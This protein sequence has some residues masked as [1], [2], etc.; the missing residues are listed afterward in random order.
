MKKRKLLSIMFLSASILS[1]A[2][3]ASCS[4]GGDSNSPVSESQKVAD[5][6]ITFKVQDENGEWKNYGEPQTI[7][8][9]K[10]T[11]PSNPTKQYYTFRGWFLDTN[12]VNEFKNENLTDGATVYAYFVADEVNIVING[13]SEGTRDLIDVING[14]Y[15][16]GE[17]LTFDGWYTDPDCKVKFNPG[18]PAKTLYAQSVA[19]ITFNNGYEDVYVTK[20][21]PN[22]TVK[23]PAL[24]SVEVDGV[25][26]TVEASQI[27][28]SYMSS[29]DVYYLDDDGNEIDFTKAITKN[30]NVHVA[31]K[32][33]FLK[34]KYCDNGSGNQ[35]LLCLGTYGDL[36]GSDSNKA[37]L[38]DVPVISFPSKVTLL[39]KE[40]NKTTHDIKG[41]YVYDNKIFDSTALKKVIVQEGIEMIR[42]FS[43]TSGT[44]GVTSFQLP[45]T[46]RI[47]Q[48]SFNNL[49]IDA[50]SV[51]IPSSVEAIYDCFFK[52]AT[53]NYN[54]E[55][56]TYYTGTA[57]DF[58]I[59][60]PDSVKS[61]SIV[62]L[63]LKFSSNSTFQN[64]GKMITQTTEK[65][66]VLI[67][68]NE[69]DENGV[70]KVPEG[71]EGIQVG[72]FVN[73]TDIR[74]LVL[75]S[76]LK[77][78]NYNLN[79]TDFQDCYGWYTGQ[80]TC[81]ECYL[82]NTTLTENDYAY[83]GRLVVSNLETINYLVFTCDVDD[84]VYKAFAG[85]ASA[86]AYYYGSFTPSNDEVYMDINTVNLKETS[87]PKVK[88][89]VTNSFTNDKYTLTIDRENQNAITYDEIFTALDKQYSTSYQSLISEKKV[90]VTKTLNMLENYDITSTIKTNL[91]M[92]IV[93]DY[94]VDQA[95][96][97]YT[98]NGDEVTITGFDEKTAINL[99][100]DSYAVIIPDVI[101]GKNVTKIA[102]GAFKEKANIKIVKL[103]KSIKTIEKNAFLDA[104][105]LDKIDFN[106]AKLE[107]IGESAFENTAVTSLSFSIASLKSVETSAFKI[108][109][110]TKFVPVNGEEARDVTNVNDG[111]FYFVPYQVPNET[112]T[113]LIANYLVLN[114][115]VSSVRDDETKLTT[116]DA[117]MYAFSNAGSI[118]ECINLG[119]DHT[120]ENYIVRY[121]VMTGAMTGLKFS[122]SC[123]LAL[124][125]V[126][127]IHTNAITDTTVSRKGIQYSAEGLGLTTSVT[128]IQTLVEALPTVFEDGWIDN[129]DSIKNVKVGALN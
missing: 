84:D 1:T 19:T 93:V 53:V 74:K 42:G 107:T 82:Y 55:S 87:T 56:L 65:G 116:Y 4:K 123:Y 110:L 51:V 59:A 16:P 118:S 63:N 2:A 99:G 128:T 88:I 24:D 34:Y 100:D 92:D 13:E 38:A 31:W 122:S 17:G 39:D 119:E 78:I 98:T 96:I 29:E 41:V 64:D 71:I 47:M 106:G 44:S 61:L 89:T 114:Q 35:I 117:K 22:E 120:D 109:S 86:Y 127:K 95:G 30:M 85:N 8:N 94:I 36:S 50:N 81:N 12:W 57:Y 103:G 11:L 33:P 67:S 25:T 40:G 72:T 97:T 70:I 52:G 58:D 3:I 69:I 32:S 37:K 14:T 129:Y 21:K 115:K 79:L 43:S 101:D 49:N 73:R 75:P 48:D 62:P 91:Y 7:V 104:I 124:N 20:I 9:G 83:C 125:H 105:A 46:L 6:A 5:K 54:N 45:S 126:S 102:E 27:V 111:E 90:A 121:E 28:K 113:A 108:S 80:Y 68:Y 26:T 77:F 66:K 112:M 23:N 10:V 18:D 76:T 15:N 60:V